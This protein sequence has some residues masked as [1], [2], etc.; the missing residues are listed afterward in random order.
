M[1]SEEWNAPSDG[2]Q[3][4]IVAR[5]ELLRYIRS[6]R[7]L[8][9]FALAA[10]IVALILIVPPALGQPY[11]KDPAYFAQRFIL[12]ANILVIVGATLFAGDALASEF[13]GR[14]G[15]LMFPNPVK[16]WV[17]FAGKYIASI[18]TMLFVLVVYYGVISILTFLH[19]GD[20][21]RLT[22]D[23][24]GLAFVY[25][26]GTIGVAY[27]VSSIMKGSTGALVFTFAILFLIFP[28]VDGVLSFAQVKP[29]FSLT[30]SAQ[31]ISAIMQ[32]PYPSDQLITAP[33][34][35]RFGG[36]LTGGENVEFF[37]YYP[38]PNLAP[39][40]MAVYAIVSVIIALIIF[41]RREMAA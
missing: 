24:F 22:L 28:I 41:R 10:L 7:L 38:D 34:G 15:Y 5:Y 16:R 23:S 30:F 20:V 25:M 33:L 9:I 18:L 35:G 6:N 4:L 17:F 14:T 8:G 26:F 12:W 37:N 13:Q 11:P 32:S 40:V 27:L 3:V 39:A 21:S 1:E 19:S 2:R 36:N 29:S 31:A